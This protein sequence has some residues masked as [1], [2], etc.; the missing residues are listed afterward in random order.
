MASSSHYGMD[1]WY[2]SNLIHIREKKKL[3]IEKIISLFCTF[4]HFLILKKCIYPEM[5]FNN[6]FKIFKNIHHIAG[7]RETILRPGSRPVWTNLTALVM[8]TEVSL[9]E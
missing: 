8:A 5:L 4:L 9:Q 6:C 7:V 3:N 1:V 2:V